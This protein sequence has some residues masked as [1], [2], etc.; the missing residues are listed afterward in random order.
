[1]AG[2][3]L[4]SLIVSVSA[5]TSAYQREMAPAY[6]QARML[7]ATNPTESAD[8]G[9]GRYPAQTMPAGLALLCGI[10]A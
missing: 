2:N 5:E 6:N 4:R 9:P 8:E 3:T 10:W 1:M 7:D